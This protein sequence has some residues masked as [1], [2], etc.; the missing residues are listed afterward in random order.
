M[1]RRLKNLRRFFEILTE[2]DGLKDTIVL[3][4][5]ICYEIL[6]YLLPVAIVF[7]VIYSLTTIAQHEDA[8]SQCSSRA[9]SLECG[10]VGNPDL[11][12]LGIRIGI[13]LQWLSSFLINVFLPEEQRS[14]AAANIIFCTALS[15]ALSILTFRRDCTYVVEVII[16]LLMIFGGFYIAVFPNITKGIDPKLKFHAT[17]V[18]FASLFIPTILFSCWFW[19]RLTIGSEYRFTPTPCGTSFFLF[20]RIGENEGN[21]FHGTA[22]MAFLSVWV[23]T[24][25][26]ILKRIVV[27]LKAAGYEKAYWAVLL[28]NFD[29]L[30]IVIG[31]LLWDYSGK[32]TSAVYNWLGRPPPNWI[33]EDNLDEAQIK[34]YVLTHYTRLTA[35]TDGN[36]AH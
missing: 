25:Y 5:W 26:M 17:D 14:S 3:A 20:T 36:A 35:A 6:V 23:V 7:G 19:I 4:G 31:V 34:M 29:G 11:Y 13:Y 18:A 9:S 15:V 1:G 33:G 21:F 32:A 2:P 27:Y 16:I 8:S 12:G 10:F 22:F 24:T 30:P 28:F